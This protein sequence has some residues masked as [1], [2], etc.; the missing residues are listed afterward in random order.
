[1]FMIVMPL[2]PALER[3]LHL[4]P[5]GFSFVVSSYTFAAGVAGVLATMVVDRFARRAAFLTI[6][7]GFLVGTLACGL[8]TTFEQLILARSLT[9]LFGGI[10]GGMALAI[11]GD[12]FPEQ[13]RGAA[14]GALMSAFALASIAGVPLGLVL[15]LS[16]GWEAPFFALVAVGVPI[17]FLAARALPRLDA[18]LSQQ[19]HERPLQRLWTTVSRPNHLRAF[20]F[21]TAMMFAGFSV[22]PFL[23]PYLVANVG[24]AE[25]D[26][27]WV[28][29]F[30]G[31]VTLVGSPIIGRLADRFGKLQVYRVVAPLNA[32]MFITA[33]TLPKS[34]LFVAVAVMSLMMITNAGRM[35]PAMALITSSVE[36][37][38]RGGF[39]GANSAVQHLASGLG[40]TFAGAVL[41]QPLHGPIE[42]YATVGWVA[43]GVT[44]FS[45]WLAGFVRPVGSQPLPPAEEV[46]AGLDASVDAAI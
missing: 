7:G 12:V 16:Y 37:K 3:A 39:L 14:T 18:H 27:P 13:R 24:V 6:F 20:A 44:L 29:I 5:A 46:V 43:A 22:I 10:L 40:A 2:G 32:V 4:T 25:R 41:T 19:T 8:A 17:W 45:L 21:T 26:L 31:L 33:T 30:G 11:V 35:V 38:Y 15:G 34:S 1:D 23:S 42:H 36:T 9:G 28:Y